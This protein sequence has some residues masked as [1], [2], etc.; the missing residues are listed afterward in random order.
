MTPP[1]S[2]SEAETAAAARDLRAPGELYDPAFHA[3]LME[4]ANAGAAA[5]A[6]AEPFPHA[7]IENFLP[8]APLARALAAYPG[9]ADIPWSRFENGNEVKLAFNRVEALPDP[10][11]EVLS[12]LNGSAAL[13]FL[14]TLTGIEGLIPDPHYVGGGLHQIEPGGRLQ[15]HADFNR[16]KEL[17][18]DRRINLILFL[19]EDWQPDYNG[20][21]ELW[22][23]DGKQSVK[24]I[25]PVVNRCVVFNTTDDA[26]HGHPR[27]L[28]CPKGRTRRSL[29]TY[30]YS[31]GRPEEE[32]S[33][34]HST[35]FI[36]E[37]HAPVR[38]AAPPLALRDF[39]PPVFGKLARRMR[40]R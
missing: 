13:R 30:Y 6:T 1:K 14:Q 25:L 28:T 26:F 7:V 16:L 32:R 34:Q 10:V 22:S 3:Q 4:R 38:P 12:F 21:L 33:E 5:Y 11:R 31:N 24:S 35:L 8:P 27:A 17:R 23:R 39:V 18:L 37:D 15:V 29:A 36:G 20:H 2:S 9:P 40:G 19:N